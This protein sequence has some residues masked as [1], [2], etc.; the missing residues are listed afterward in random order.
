MVLL[1]SLALA[2]ALLAALAA[3][4]SAQTAPI[5]SYENR[6]YAAGA[7]APTQTYT[8][9]A[10]ATVCNQADPGSG[11]TVNPTRLI[12][13][14]PANPGRVC[15]HQFAAGSTLFSLPIGNYEGTLIAVNQG[16]ASGESPRAPFSRL[17]PPSVPSGV[18]YGR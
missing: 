8:F 17:G 2:V 11:V 3:A 18:R 13:D 5:D 14:D 15:I 16:G 7:A 12:W 4:V 9:P 1:R 6:H 10:T